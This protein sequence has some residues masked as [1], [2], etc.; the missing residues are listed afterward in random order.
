MV[1]LEVHVK[2]VMA[3][4]S[5]EDEYF[6]LFQEWFIDILSFQNNWLIFGFPIQ[7]T[8]NTSLLLQL[9]TNNQQQQPPRKA[10]LHIWACASECSRIWKRRN[11]NNDRFIVRQNNTYG[12]T[13]TGRCH[14][15]RSY[16]NGTHEDVVKTW[17]TLTGVR[18]VRCQTRTTF[19]PSTSL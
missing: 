10:Q 15:L 12:K 2:D 19:C 11:M 6:H 1:V 14:D 17:Y 9:R 16:H 8:T 13:C 5:V 18:T 7:D 4:S 3:F